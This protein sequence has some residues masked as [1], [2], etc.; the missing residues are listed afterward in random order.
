MLVLSRMEGQRIIIGDN[1]VVTV[2]QVKGDKVR[3]G[4]EAPRT[5][6]VNREELLEEKSN[7]RRA[8][9]GPRR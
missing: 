9:D 4:V 8:K 2:I 7:Y 5:I 3:I 6:E 1:I